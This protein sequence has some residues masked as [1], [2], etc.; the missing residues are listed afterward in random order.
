MKVDVSF[1]PNDVAAG[2]VA[3]RSVVVIDVLRATTTLCAAL[4]NGARAVVPALAAD[5]ATA[6]AQALGSGD[7]LLTGERSLGRITGF[8]LGNS[9]LEM[10]RTAVNGKLLV[11]TTTNGTRA[12]RATAGAREVILAAGVNLTTA[13]TRA[14]QM[15]EANGDLLVLCAGRDDGFALDDAY[16]AGLM[17]VAAMGGSRTRRGLNDAAIAAVDLVRRYGDRL[18]RVL[19]LSGAGRGLKANGYSA[20]VEYACRIDSHPVLPVFHDRRITLAP[21][22]NS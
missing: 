22:T 7:V 18:D 13:G 15:L 1:A 14:R 8:D 5:E 9:P 6:L 16:L 10:T 4:D 20:D 19:T 12:I 11:T 3:G 17:V 2:D 21:V